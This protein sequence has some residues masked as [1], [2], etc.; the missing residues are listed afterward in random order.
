ML[1]GPP[2]GRPPGARVDSVQITQEPFKG[3]FETFEVTFERP[4][5]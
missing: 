2:G 3:E 5:P 1:T 4:S